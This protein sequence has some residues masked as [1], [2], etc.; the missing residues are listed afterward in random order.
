MKTMYNMRDEIYMRK[1]IW[2]VIAI[3]MLCGPISAMAQESEGSNIRVVSAAGVEL[4][5]KIYNYTSG[6]YDSKVTWSNATQGQDWVLADQCLEITHGNFSPSWGIQIYTDNMNNDTYTVIGSVNSYNGNQNPAGLVGQVTTTQALPVAWIAYADWQP[7]DSLPDNPIERPFDLGGFTGGRWHM[8][9]DKNPFSISISFV[10]VN[11]VYHIKITIENPP[12]ATHYN[13][14]GSSDLVSNV[15]N[16]LEPDYLAQG[17]SVT[18]WID[19]DP[20]GTTMFYKVGI[21]QPTNF[22]SPGEDYVTIWSQ[23]GVA[24]GDRE[25]ER[26]GNPEKVYLF[27]AAKFSNTTK[28]VYKTNSL[29]LEHFTDDT[30]QNPFPFYI[31]KEGA[32]AMQM[33]YEHLGS[34]MDTYFKGSQKRLLES[35]SD[36]YPPGPLGSLEGVAFTYDNAVA[37]CT[38]L[39]RPTEENLSRAKLLVQSFIWAEEN[40]S[41]ADNRL[42][43]AYDARQEFTG[44]TPPLLGSEFDAATTGNM[45]WVIN[46]FS[47]YYKNSNDTDTI[48]L[49][50]IVTAA[51]NA[52]DFIHNNFY[53]AS[54]SGYFYGFN[55]DGTTINTSKSTEHNITVYVAFSHIYDIT[56]DS[57]WLTRAN[58]AKD[59]VQNIAWIP[60]DDRYAAGLYSGGSIN[61]VNLVADVNL[62]AILALGDA[63]SADISETVE[64]VKETFEAEVGVANEIKG[65]D[66]GYNINNSSIEPD[67]VWFEGTAQLAQA[68]K[69]IGHYGHTDNSNTYLES[70]KLAQYRDFWPTNTGLNANYKAIP[71]ASIEETNGGL[72]TGLGWRYYASAHV[73]STA[74][75]AAAELNYNLLWGTALDADVPSPG[76]NISFSADPNSLIDDTEYLSNH[77]YPSGWMN[78]GSNMYTDPRSTQ[79]VYGDTCFKIHY[80]GAKG[81]DGYTWNSLVFQEPENEWTGGAGL[82]YDLSGATKIKFRIKASRDNFWVRTYLGYPGDSSSVIPFNVINQYLILDTSWQ[83]VEIDL[84]ENNNPGNIL[85]MS[86]V[87][88]GFTIVFD[89]S[90]PADIYID[91]IRYDD[92]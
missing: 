85:D 47:Q 8:L 58:N 43:D 34:K 91:D 5:A 84:E 30:T 64:Y 46:A 39:A 72:T 19:P 36:P 16:L 61:L 81:Q 88:N 53:D 11:G 78:S 83:N 62:L 10:R 1:L 38:Y 7:G 73:A 41:F 89:G 70:I 40:D 48:F 3:L 18:E 79:T 4:D 24:V 35:Y 69:V 66:F 9:K 2:V 57:K 76:D 55:S 26:T 54:Q 77:Y 45:A 13:I 60:A 71:A 51:E 87:S 42:R 15:W 32:P 33:A 49:S 75:L 23:K 22:F 68:Y 25:D 74:W 56:G 14:Y 90:V 29:S 37:V 82:G 59:F 17:G 86:H 31:Y 28:Q 65:I 20:L 63:Q 67:G 52:G 6:V 12:G 50:E 92:N 27:L 80:T 44:S 21:S